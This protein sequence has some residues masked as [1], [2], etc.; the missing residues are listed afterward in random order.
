MQW[1]EIGRSKL[2][3]AVFRI[4][5]SCIL[6]EIC[7]SEHYT[8]ITISLPHKTT[9]ED[10]SLALRVMS[11]TDDIAQPICHVHGGG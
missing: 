5:I 10:I 1:L 11:R 2:Y 9:G 8:Y 4:K 7:T 3:N 6:S